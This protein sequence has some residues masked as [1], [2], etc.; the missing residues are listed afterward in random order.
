MSTKKRGL[1]RGLNELGLNELLKSYNNQ[2]SVVPQIL[3]ERPEKNDSLLQEIPIHKIKPGKYQPRKTIAQD[4]LE[5]LANSIKAQGLIQPIVV[6]PMGENYELIAGE[7]R[8]RAV[9]LIGWEKIPAIVK[10]I[11][12][13]AAVAISLIENIQ[14]RDLNPIEEAVAL[15]RLISEFEMTHQQVAEAV[16][17]SRSAISNLLRLLNLTPDV[18]IMLEQ[19]NIEMGHARALLALEGG[20]QNQVAKR[21][22]S[23]AWSVRET[24]HY[25]RQIQNTQDESKGAKIAELDPDILNL[26]QSL[27][28]KLGKKVTIRHNAK[29]KGLLIIYYNNSKEFNEILQ[30]ID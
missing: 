9:Q 22:V 29:G 5:E 12:D 20:V 16:G 2:V 28:K 23:K 30:R 25:I 27:S 6:R 21:I 26:Q 1:G 17:K 4:A 8:W 24:E 15:Q 3:N 10:D 11:S 18:S 19:G 13:E 7:R 14:R